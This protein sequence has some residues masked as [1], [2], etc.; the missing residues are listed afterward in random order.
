MRQ[1]RRI[2][3]RDIARTTFK[4]YPK[5]A[6]L[7]LSLFVGQAFI[8]NAV[9]ITL[10][11]TLTTYFGVGANKVGLF[12]AVFAAGNFMGP[13]LLGRLFDTVGRKP[14]IAG[15]YLLS[16]VMLV[17]VA[18]LFGSCDPKSCQGQFSDWTVTLALA[19]TFFFASAGA[20]SAY[21]TVSEVFPMEMRALAIAFFYAIGTA[22]GGITGPQV[23]QKLGESGTSGVVTAYLI[24]AAV[25]AVGGIVEIFL[26]VRAEQ[27]RLEDI[28]KPI[29]AREAE[30]AEA[31]A[32]E[33]TPEEGRA[34]AEE[35]AERRHRAR[36]ERERA[37]L[38]RYRPGPGSGSF[39]PFFGHPAAPPRPEWLDQEIEIISQALQQQ[40]ELSSRGAR[41]AHRGAILGPGPVPRRSARSRGRRRRAPN[42]AIELRRAKRERQGRRKQR[43]GLRPVGPCSPAVFSV[44]ASS[45][46]RRTRR[47]G[48]NASGNAAS[49]AISATP[50]RLMP[51]A[52]RAPSIAG[53]AMTSAAARRSR[54]CHSGWPGGRAASRRDSPA[55]GAGNQSAMAELVLGPIL[56]HVGERDATVWVEADEACQVE[57]LGHTEPTFCVDGHHYALVCIEGLEP[58]SRFEYEVSLDGERRWP[59]ADSAFPASQ[60]RTLDPGRAL[61]VSFGSCRVALPMKPPYVDPK[62][63]HD[64]G[65]EV[66]ALHV[67]AHELLRDPDNRWPDLLLM[68]GDQVYVDEGSPETREFIRSRRDVSEPPGD[69]GARLRGVH[70]PL[71]RIVERAVRPLAVLDRSERDGDRR[72]RHQRRL[73]HLPLL[74][75]GDGP[76]ALVAPAG[77]GGLHDLLDLPAPGQPLPRRAV[78]GRDLRQGQGVARRRRACASRLREAGLRGSRGDPVELPPRPLRHPRDRHGLARRSRARGGTPVDL[79]RGGARVGLGAGRGRL[80]PP[81]DRDVRPLPALARHPPSRGLERGRLRRC[82]GRRG[83]SAGREAPARRGLRPLGVVRALLPAPLRPAARGGIL[84]SGTLLPHRSSCSRAT[85]TMPT[86]RRWAS[87]AAA[88]SKAAST[89]RSARHFGIRWTSASAA[90]YGSCFERRRR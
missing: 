6:V 45:S 47:C 84:R 12:Y 83:G 72:S 71:S 55:L 53:T 67:Y 35:E 48:G 39:S 54:S 56:R 11:L 41:P 64:E 65:A 5:R 27:R 22:I 31:P 14:M 59:V 38:R 49:A 75:G 17:G 2:P 66:D 33:R 29:T 81:A 69:R 57:V 85:C 19:A 73:E 63:E 20:S 1:R 52:T 86:W 89:R 60:I 37:G 76:Q 82:L 80:R 21:L 28:A 40:G 7:G 87:R 4:T 70:A 50:A 42:L 23:F 8:Y 88:A 34:E 24:G 36:I 3:W 79:R 13:L 74:E 10:G 51:S 68:L 61:R 46:G 78:G 16:A 30:G 58:G 32:T 62:D 44:T 26:G 43:S 9:T 77:G 18:L 15:T 25:M 90:S